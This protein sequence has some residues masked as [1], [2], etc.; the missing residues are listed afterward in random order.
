M[1][2]TKPVSL[3]LPTRLIRLLTDPHDIVLDCF[4]GSG[5]TALA[6]LRAHRRYLGIEL[7]ERYVQLAKASI[8]SGI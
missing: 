4:L 8:A 3:E 7:E 1:T 2:T 6:A 5:T